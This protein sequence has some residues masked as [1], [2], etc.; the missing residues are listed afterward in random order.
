MATAHKKYG[1]SG[2]K[3]VGLCPGATKAKAECPDSSSEAA[4]R[5][6]RIHAWLEKYLKGDL[7]PPAKKLEGN[8][9]IEAQIGAFAG[10]KIK[11]VISEL[12]MEL[13][14]FR[15]EQMTSFPGYEEIAGGTPDLWGYRAFGDL[16]VIDLKTGNQQVSAVESEQ[17]P[18][19]GVSAAN[20]ID[21]FDLAT[22]NDLVNVIVQ[23][24]GDTLDVEVRISRTPMS[25]LP[26][27][28]EYFKAQIE[29]AE[30]YPDLRTP[31]EHCQALYCDART[32]CDEYLK[33][34]DDD[35]L[36]TLSR[37]LEGEKVESPRGMRLAKLL[38]ARKKIEDLI[39]QAKADAVAVLKL[40]PQGVPGYHLASGLGDRYFPDEKK[41]MAAFKLLGFKPD[42][43]APRKLIGIG[44]AEELLKKAGIELEKLP[45]TARDTTLS[46]KKGDPE[47]VF[48]NFAPEEATSPKAADMAAAG[49]T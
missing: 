10:L 3:L 2:I 9:L 20:E 46:L 30:A 17:L 16:V 26:V 48:A 39:K 40:D 14:D 18:Y 28:R 33:W 11:D 34:V 7:T 27:W 12:G 36:Q 43:Y 13:S 29:R 35:S 21:P 45:D 15:I 32:T 38:D 5:G 19:Y 41:A 47:N 44:K 8:E 31:G 23:T 42:E 22:L 37:L 6:N 25:E 24:Q 1:G 49:T 4:D